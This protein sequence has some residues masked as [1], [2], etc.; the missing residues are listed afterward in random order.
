MQPPTQAVVSYEQF[1]FGHLF[2]TNIALINAKILFGMIT[3]GASLENL[4]AKNSCY[5]GKW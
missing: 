3:N 4:Q 5:Q 1:V 2:F